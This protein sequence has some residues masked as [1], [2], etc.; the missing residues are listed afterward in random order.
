VNLFIDATNIRG[1]GGL[2]HLNSILEHANPTSFIFSKVIVCSSTD[3][4]NR[5]PNHPWLIK[6]GEMLIDSNSYFD[7]WRWRKFRFREVLKAYGNPILFCVG[8]IKPPFDYSYYTI[9]Q[10]L[11]PL[12]LRELLR[13]GFSLVTLRLLILRFVH[14]KA[15]RNAEGVIFLTQHCYEVLPTRIKRDLKKHTVIHHGIDHR[16]FKRTGDARFEGVTKVLYVSN[17]DQYKHQDTVAQAVINL[18][19]RAIPV[20]L[21]LVGSSYKPTL[22][23]LQRVMGSVANGRNWVQIKGV[24]S[25]QEQIAEYEK[26]D[27]SLIASSCE[28]FGMTLTESLAL[29][30][31]IACSSIPSFK[32]IAQDAAVYFDPQEVK[33]IERAIEK[34]ATDEYLRRVLSEKAFTRAQAFSWEN[35][36]RR[37][38]DFLSN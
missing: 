7:R 21:S 28:S 8:T 12:E 32:E 9:C 11:L 2:V 13:F 33:S 23:R 38:F 3:T 17:I 18:N 4:L 34:L 1:G 16:L 15:Y 20:Q 36:S 37:T 10:N 25:H 14:L 27:I 29:G 22:R 19:Q 5:L 35:T 24:M 31:P 26:S 30:M 6:H